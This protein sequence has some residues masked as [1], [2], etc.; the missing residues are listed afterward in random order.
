[1]GSATNKGVLYLLPAW[2][3]DA[4]GV[5]LMPSANVAIAERIT[6]YFAEHERT[7]R[8]MLK[9]LSPQIDMKALE[10]YRLDKDTTSEEVEEMAALLATRDGAIMSEAGMPC[11]ADP[12]ARLVGAAHRR[13]IRVIPLAGPSSLLLALAASGLNGQHF[14]F[15]GYLPRDGGAR[16]KAIRE[17]ETRSAAEGGAQLF[18]ETPYR[19]SAM[20]AD[21]LATC[22]E[23]TLLC[24]A[25]S[26][27]QEDEM[28]RTLTIADWRGAAP[29]IDDRPA[30]Y[31]I[32]R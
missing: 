24:I 9:R 15:H 6:L 5:E 14:I 31:I 20:I 13:G 7:A 10:I 32:Q 17:L 26:I 12:G 27:G 28:I 1:M 18:I 19:N 3:G 21:L 11:I 22:H 8:A 29:A 16:R 2:L 25:A 30:V 4:G 23:R